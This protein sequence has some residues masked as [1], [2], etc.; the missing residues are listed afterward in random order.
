MKDSVINIQQGEWPK[1]FESDNRPSFFNYNNKG[2]IK[3]RLGFIYFVA[4]VS[5]LIILFA[6]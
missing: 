1:T 4:L 2:K 3:A 5:S 6:K